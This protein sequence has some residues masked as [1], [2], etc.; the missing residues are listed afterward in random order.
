MVKALND[1]RMGLVTPRVNAFINSV[2]RPLRVDGDVKPTKLF[3]TNRYALCAKLSATLRSSCTAVTVVTRLAVCRCQGGGRSER[4]RDA[5]AAAPVGSVPVHELGRA[6][7]RHRIR[8]GG[9]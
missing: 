4:E 7:A 2:R 8:V 9:V 3:C 1:V 6:A 5:A